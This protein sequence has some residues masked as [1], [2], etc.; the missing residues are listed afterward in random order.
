MVRAGFSNTKEP[1]M[2]KL[3]FAVLILP[4]L[5]LSINCSSQKNEEETNKTKVTKLETPSQK[6]GYALGADI[7]NSFKRNQMV[8][9]LQAFIQG[10]KDGTNGGTMLLTPEEIKVVQKEAI[11]NMRQ[12]IEQGQ[13]LTAEKNIVA[14]EKFLSENSKK[15]GVITTDS[16]LQ[17]TILT[18]GSGAVPT[19][20][21]KVRVNYIGTLLD[22][23]EFDSSLKRGKPAE[24]GV[25]GVIAGWTEALQLMQ[26]GSKWKLFLPAKLAYGPRGAG[27]LIG[28]N[29]TLIFEVELIDIIKQQAPSEKK[30]SVPAAAK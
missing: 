20:T 28:A 10:F 19:A 30:A 13:K 11:A 26:V 8:V 29:S 5:F 24:F 17:Y 22:G 25:K 1:M 21:D 18:K 7:S 27:K 16:G 4:L 15:D 2:K 3:F 6:L 23:T 12:K 14:G 9:D